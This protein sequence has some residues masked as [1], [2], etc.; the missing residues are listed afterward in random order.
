[1]DVSCLPAGALIDVHITDPQ[2]G[3]VYSH[4]EANPLWWTPARIALV[5]HM[6]ASAEQTGEGLIPSQVAHMLHKLGGGK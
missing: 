2:F 6:V 4:T 1:V 3:D 5:W